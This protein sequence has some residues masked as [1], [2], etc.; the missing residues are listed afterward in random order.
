VAPVIGMGIVEVGH[1][2]PFG[3]LKL[4]EAGACLITTRAQKFPTDPEIIG[5]L[6]RL[7]IAQADYQR[8]RS[9]P[10]LPCS[11]YQPRPR[12]PPAPP[13]PPARPSTRPLSASAAPRSSWSVAACI[14]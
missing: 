9:S 12:H 3:F 13:S 5:E 11:S 6:R 2:N 8:P 10:Q 4:F 7:H 14:R 1:G